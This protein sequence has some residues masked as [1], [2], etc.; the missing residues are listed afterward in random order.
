MLLAIDIGNT[1][2]NFGVFKENRLKK[3][4]FLPTGA[5]HTKQLRHFLAKAKTD[6]SIICSVVPQA[7][8]ILEK[9]IMQAFHYRPLILGKNI[10]ASI[11][12]LYRYPRQVGQDRL[13]NAYAA[14]KLYPAPLIVVD[15]GTATTFDIISDKK[16]Y[17]GGMIL[18]G[19]QLSL[20]A[21]FQYTALLPKLKLTNPKEFIGRDTKSSMLSGIVY[22]L[23]ALTDGL[24]KKIKHKIG[25]QAQVIGTGGNISLMA[26]YCRCLN[27]I[28]ADLTLK[29]LNLISQ[30]SFVKLG[31]RTGTAIRNSLHIPCIFSNR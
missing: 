28:D 29:G 10:N 16:E 19:L 23:A 21:L 25:N 8:K 7:T 15:F 31:K 26:R 9:A 4:F 24:S 18:P 12:N 13:V 5:L 30:G 20:D 17:L 22:G 2:T 1:N 6:S 11:K 27:Q 3:R 14:V